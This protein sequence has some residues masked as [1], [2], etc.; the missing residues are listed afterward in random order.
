MLALLSDGGVRFAARRLV[1]LA[2]GD[3]DVHD[4][5]PDRMSF[6]RASLPALVLLLSTSVAHAQEL[7]ALDAPSECVFRRPLA[8][9][10]SAMLDGPVRA[11][12]EVTI[13]RAGPIWEVDVVVSPEHEGA[14]PQHR[15]IAGT[16]EAS[17]ASLEDSLVVVLATMLE[18]YLSSGPPELATP[19]PCPPRPAPEPASPPEPERAPPFRIEARTGARATWG[20]LPDTAFGGIAAIFVAREQWAM[21]LGA[22]IL[23]PSTRWAD[24]AR[25]ASFGAV[26]FGLSACLRP[27][28]DPI[29]MFETCVRAEG[30][31]IEAAG[32]G[33]ESSLR[34]TDAWFSL[35]ASAGGELRLEPVAIGAELALQGVFTPIQYVWIEGAMRTPVYSAWPLAISISLWARVAVELP[36]DR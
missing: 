18:P 27:S 8:E 9:R 15:H 3:V 26:L 14:W 16:E 19:E 30:G 36:G 31:P 13:S 34:P 22:S 35:G 23:P 25:G 2:L 4:I 6:R 7:I 5:F 33:F 11:S 1:S 32:F 12:A 29:A 21:G 17:C 28:S 20:V 10:V 24:E